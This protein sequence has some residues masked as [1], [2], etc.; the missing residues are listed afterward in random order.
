[1]PAKHL[2]TEQ[3]GF[4]DPEIPGEVFITQKCWMKG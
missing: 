2:G 4:P 3:F 1:M